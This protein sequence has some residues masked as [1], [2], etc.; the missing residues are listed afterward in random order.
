MLDIIAHFAP[1]DVFPDECYE[2]LNYD[3]SDPNSSYDAFMSGTSALHKKPG[4]F[5]WRVLARGT[6]GGVDKFLNWLVG[7]EAWRGPRQ[8]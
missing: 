3:S 5:S 4:N 6:D 7:I 1:R 8:G 2:V